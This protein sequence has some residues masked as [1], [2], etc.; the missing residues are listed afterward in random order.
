MKLSRKN[1]RRT[2]PV[3][4]THSGSLQRIYTCVC[5]ASISMCNSYPVTRRV[6]DFC[7]THNM[8]CADLYA[9]IK[10]GKKTVVI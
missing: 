10:S 3:A 6:N 7:E 2:N 9:A 4:I 5:G 8:S 1:M